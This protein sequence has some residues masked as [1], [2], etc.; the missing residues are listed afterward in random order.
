MR[1]G[2]FLMKNRSKQIPNK[3]NAQSVRT[4]AP[5][6]H[7]R[8]YINQRILRIRDETK[9]LQEE[10]LELRQAPGGGAAKDPKTSHRRIYVR[11]RLAILREETR[12][13]TAERQAMPKK[14]SPPEPEPPVLTRQ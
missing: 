9:A 6:Y 11:E 5:P 3:P 1:D 10:L 14:S 7:R 8:V 4:E 2:C 12:S 13:L